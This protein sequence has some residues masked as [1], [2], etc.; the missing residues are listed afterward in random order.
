MPNDP[1]NEDMDELESSSSQEATTKKIDLTKK[2]KKEEKPKAIDTINL[3]IQGK[4]SEVMSSSLL[5]KEE[6]QKIEGKKVL[7]KIERKADVEDLES[8]LQ[9]DGKIG[10][11]AILLPVTESIRE[12]LKP[13]MQFC[14]IKEIPIVSSNG[15]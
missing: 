5:N 6:L 8:Y 2:D 12:E 13:L 4:L 7:F 1:Q 3:I 10:E 9:S 14:M 15:E 11:L